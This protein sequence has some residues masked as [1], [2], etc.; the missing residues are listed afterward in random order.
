M[1]LGV[2]LPNSQK[3]WRKRADFSAQPER[4]FR[5]LATDVMVS[6]VAGSS[7]KFSATVCQNRY[8]SP[9]PS[10]RSGLSRVRPQ[11]VG[12]DGQ[13]SAARTLPGFQ[14]SYAREYTGS[15]THINP[16][17][18]LPRP[19]ILQGNTLCRTFLSFLSLAACLFWLRPVVIRIWN[20]QQ[21]AHLSAVPQRTSLAKMLQAAHLSVAH[22]V[23]LAPRSAPA[24]AK[25]THTTKVTAMRRSDH[26]SGR[27]FCV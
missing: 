1:I 15:V 26:M 6:D 12:G 11:F 13:S 3:T 20:A 14:S 9:S 24:K 22:T 10:T 8:P 25:T 23:A 18:T 4:G 19:A 21:R 5:Q 27:R 16:E 2:I 7:S 17:R